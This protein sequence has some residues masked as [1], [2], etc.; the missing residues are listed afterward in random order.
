MAK[1]SKS[2]DKPLVTGIEVLE[3]FDPSEEAEVDG[4][5]TFEAKLVPESIPDDMV[6]LWAHQSDVGFYKGRGYRDARAGQ[7]EVRLLCG[8]EFAEGETMRF[9]DH[10]LLLAPKEQFSRRYSNERF[11]NRET[12]KAILRNATGSIELGQ[13]DKRAMGVKG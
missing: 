9:R 1:G 10:Q 7:D 5:P 6:P 13:S 11:R 12:R 3:R 4:D 8:T 2:G